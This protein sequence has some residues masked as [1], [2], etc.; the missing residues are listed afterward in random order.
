MP[1]RVSWEVSESLVLVPQ[2]PIREE[3][4]VKSP[5]TIAERWVARVGCR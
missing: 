5:Q 1:H 2:R 4:Q 3:L